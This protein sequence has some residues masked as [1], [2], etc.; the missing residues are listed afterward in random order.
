[1]EHPMS[2]TPDQW[3][4]EARSRIAISEGRRAVR[5]FDSV[6]VPTIGI[7]FNLN[8]SDAPAEITKLGAHWPSIRRG[9]VGLTDAQIDALF[10]Y[11]FAPIASEARASLA[12]GTFDALSDARRFVVCDLVFNLGSAGWQG[13]GGTRSLIDQGVAAHKAGDDGKAH[14]LFGAA[15]DHLQDSAWY[16]QVGNRAKRNVAM[17]RSSGWVDP[18][19][20]GS[21]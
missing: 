19:G 14:L 3:L 21:Q 18:N 20:D 12:P 6:G 7:G 11:S 2:M 10:A 5:Y 16:S 15:A 17:L 4:A 9:E 13:F 1:M 8:R